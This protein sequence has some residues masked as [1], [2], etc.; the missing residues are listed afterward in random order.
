MKDNARDSGFLLSQ[1]YNLGVLCRE[2][3]GGRTSARWEHR[4]GPSC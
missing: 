4:T 1:E 2:G 3:R